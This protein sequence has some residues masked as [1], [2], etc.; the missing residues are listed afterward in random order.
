MMLAA[1][2]LTRTAQSPGTALTAQSVLRFKQNPVRRGCI[3]AD[4]SCW[5][6]YPHQF[7]RPVEANS[8]TGLSYSCRKPRMLSG[9]QGESLC[10]LGCF[11]ARKDGC[12]S[13]TEPATFRSRDQSMRI[14]NRSPI[15]I[16]CRQ[17]RSIWLRRK[18]MKM[19]RKK[20]PKAKCFVV[21]IDS[22][23]RSA[24]FLEGSF[25]ESVGGMLL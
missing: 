2:A 12:R 19:M 15:S 20:V 22:R 8:D 7:W 9:K 16:N 23:L 4:L 25:Q 21:V 13:I 18:R 24:I 1:S 5:R 14:I 17:K 10:P 11:V 3:E 6:R